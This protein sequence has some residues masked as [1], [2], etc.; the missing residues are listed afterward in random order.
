MVNQIK[1]NFNN[2]MNDNYRKG[3]ILAGGK[4]TR[5]RPITFSV[6]K[7][8]L[9]LYNKPAIYYPLTTLMLSGIREFL[10]I[11]NPG[12]LNSFKFSS[13]IALEKPYFD[14]GFLLSLTSYGEFLQPS[15]T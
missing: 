6:C 7:Q 3:I 2:F 8:L 4:G 10:I 9:P 11:V 1:E 5:L 15:K 14:I 12:D 13:Q